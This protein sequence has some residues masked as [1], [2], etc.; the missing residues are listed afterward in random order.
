MVLSFVAILTFVFAPKKGIWVKWLKQRR[1]R[2]LMLEENILKTC[3][4]LSHNKPNTSAY[5]KTS[6]ILHQRNMSNKQLLKGIAALMDEGYLVKEKEHY[7]QL[8]KE[9]L[10]QGERVARLHR[11]WELYLTEYLRIAPDHVHDDAETIEHI[12][13]PELQARLETILGNPDVGIE[14]S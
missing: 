10:K 13:T 11:L 2:Q 12:L 4:Y 6:D 5:F 7:Y 3:F 1:I 8:T 14:I 9:G